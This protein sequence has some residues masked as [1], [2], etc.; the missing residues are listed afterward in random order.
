[1]ADELPWIQWYPAKWLG[2]T[3]LRQCSSAARGLWIDIL[4]FMH[5]CT[6]YGHLVIRGK[7][8]TF[9]QIASLIGGITEAQVKARLGELEDAGVFDRDEDGVIISRRMIRDN[10]KRS[11]AR[12]NGSKGGNPN[13]RSRLTEQVNLN[14]NQEPNHRVNGHLNGVD[15][16]LREE[17]KRE[18]KKRKGER[19]ARVARE[20]PSLSGRIFSG[21]WPDADGLECA[22]E[23]G[24]RTAE[25]MADHIGQF[26]DVYT[27]KGAS[28]NDWQ[29]QWRV[30][31]R[32][33][34]GT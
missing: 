14:P 22:N 31:C 32:R 28:L 27:A 10:A 13:L 20:T 30:W 15:N 16:A 19:G 23:V 34:N 29:A 24:I 3:G 6:P 21:W 25:Q 12:A 26:I 4:M 17:K 33:R 7:P 9:R 1:M 2:D 5:T 11:I 18:E 8:P